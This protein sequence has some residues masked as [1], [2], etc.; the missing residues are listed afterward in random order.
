MPTTIDVLEE[1]QRVARASGID[2]RPDW[3]NGSSG[4]YCRIGNQRCI[5]VDLSLPADEQLVQMMLALMD[6]SVPVERYTPSMRRAHQYLLHL[7]D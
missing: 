1:S 5:F 4:G 2:V 3:L 7:S 6:A